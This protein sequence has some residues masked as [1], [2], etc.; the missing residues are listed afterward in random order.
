MKGRPLHVSFK[1]PHCQALKVDISLT[2]SLQPPHVSISRGVEIAGGRGGSIGDQWGGEV[3]SHPSTLRL[4]RRWLLEAKKSQRKQILPLRDRTLIKLAV[5]GYCVESFTGRSPFEW[6]DL[7]NEIIDQTSV[8]IIDCVDSTREQFINNYIHYIVRATTI[9]NQQQ[10]RHDSHR[11]MQ[12]TQTHRHTHTPIPTN[13]FLDMI[14][15]TDTKPL[16]NDTR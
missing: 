8:Y 14:A 9:R 16:H 4:C 5:F 10:M 15:T 11:W 12:S 3:G 7:S 2:L 6:H 1:P 13:G